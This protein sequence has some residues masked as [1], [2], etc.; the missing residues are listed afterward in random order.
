[1][2]STSPLSP[3]HCAKRQL[4]EPDGSMSMIVVW[5]EGGGLVV[6]KLI[7]S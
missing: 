2:S 7:E 4:P 5:L 6:V 1:M 3:K